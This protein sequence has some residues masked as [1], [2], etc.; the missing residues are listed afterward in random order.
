[1]ATKK[2]SKR[3]ASTTARRVTRKKRNTTPLD[4]IAQAPVTSD[5]SVH[6]Y[7]RSLGDRLSSISTTFGIILAIAAFFGIVAGIARYAY[8]NRPS[9]TQLLAQTAEYEKSIA[10]CGRKPFLVVTTTND[11]NETTYSYYAPGHADYERGATTLPTQTSQTKRFKCD[12]DNT[13]IAYATPYYA[14]TERSLIAGLYKDYTTAKGVR[15]LAPTYVPDGYRMVRQSLSSTT[16]TVAYSA[17]GDETVDGY[18]ISCSLLRDA[19]DR[20][21]VTKYRTPEKTIQ[22]V[23]GLML[24]G[25]T[26]LVAGTASEP[27]VSYAETGDMWCRFVKNGERFIA[28][29][30]IAAIMASLTDQPLDIVL[31]A[32]PVATE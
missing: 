18:F 24:Y 26:V 11:Y 19:P 5:E 1:M 17:T 20:A 27:Q 12:L 22:S 21:A 2:H 28:N 4:A 31:Q 10:V 3:T 6:L 32:S 15:Y 30:T 14:N 29:T 16:Y 25:D 23:N 9:R 8:L 13:L 7:H